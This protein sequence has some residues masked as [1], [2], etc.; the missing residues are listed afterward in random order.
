MNRRAKI[1]KSVNPYKNQHHSRENKSLRHSANRSP[2]M[3]RKAQIGREIA[4]ENE[5]K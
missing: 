3:T 1:N 2:F 4:K 5:N